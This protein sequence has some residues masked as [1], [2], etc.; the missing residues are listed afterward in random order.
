MN[1]TEG[2]LHKIWYGISHDTCP[3]TAIEFTTL[4]SFYTWEG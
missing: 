3:I 4:L 1:T 2:A